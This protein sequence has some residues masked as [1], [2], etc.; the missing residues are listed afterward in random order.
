MD[1]VLEVDLRRRQA[2]RTAAQA[3]LTLS[4]PPQPSQEIHQGNVISRRCRPR[5]NPPTRSS[6]INRPPRN[7]KHKERVERRH[8]RHEADAAR[9]QAQMETEQ[10]S[11]EIEDIEPG[12]P[13]PADTP[14][15]ARRDPM[16]AP[17]APPAER[18]G[19]SRKR[20]PQHHHT[21]DTLI[22]GTASAKKPR[23]EPHGQHGDGNRDTQGNR[24]RRMSK[25]ATDA[26]RNHKHPRRGGRVSAR[27]GLRRGGE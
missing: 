21:Q 4:T 7:A 3:E 5:A 20:K 10:V 8:K 17:R 15:P 19:G 14:D 27:G 13:V 24:K 6:E 18:R 22:T 2:K 26:I 16:V 12:M 9:L 1:N 11:V 23:T 25:D